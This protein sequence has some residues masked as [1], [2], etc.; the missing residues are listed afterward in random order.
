MKIKRDKRDILFSELIRER[1]GKCMFCGK[2]GRLECSHFWGRGNKGTRFDPQNCEA[3]CFR[4]HMLNEGNKQGYYREY[5]LRT[6]GEEEYKKLEERAKGFARY[7]KR[8]K[9]I[10]YQHLKEHGLLK[11]DELYEKI[12]L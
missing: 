3:L 1:D 7:G 4:C 11:Y 2:E 6:L 10:V 8:E 12:K 5:K 9:E